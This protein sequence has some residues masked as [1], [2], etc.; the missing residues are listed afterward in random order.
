[1]TNMPSTQPNAPDFVY[2]QRDDGINVYVLNRPTR[3]AIDELFE[4]GTRNDDLA[5]AA[6]RHVRSMIDLRKIMPTPYA[7]A[8]IV[9]SIASA[10]KNL[11]QS[12]AVITS[13]SITA[14]LLRNIVNKLSDSEKASIQLFAAPEEGLEW[15]EQRQAEIGE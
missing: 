4:V 14:N 13:N 12:I 2:Y 15:L 11:R 8:K 9:Q 5:L 10:P 6:N 3:P 1:M 7:G